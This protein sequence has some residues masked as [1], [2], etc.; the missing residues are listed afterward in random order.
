MLFVALRKGFLLMYFTG[1][2]VGIKN[3]G[4]KVFQIYGRLAS[5][6]KAAMGSI[7]F[8]IRYYEYYMRRNG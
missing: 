6:E 8:Q 3:K 7:T 2:F 4:V 5:L 1:I